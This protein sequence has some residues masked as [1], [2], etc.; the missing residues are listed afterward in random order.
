[1]R[2]ESDNSV[3]DSGFAKLVLDRPVLDS[4]C[5]LAI[6]SKS[7]QLYLHPGG[8]AGKDRHIF[9]VQR[10]DGTTLRLGPHVVNQLREGD[11]VRIELSDGEI[12]G[13][14][15]WTTLQR[16][17]NAPSLIRTTRL[18]PARVHVQ[19]TPRPGSDRLPNTPSSSEYS[20]GRKRQSAGLI[21]AACGIILMLASLGYLLLDRLIPLLPVEVR[22]HASAEMRLAEALRC[23]DRSSSCAIESTCFKGLGTVLAPVPALHAQANER[24]RIAMH[25]CDQVS[26]AIS[27]LKACSSRLRCDMASCKAS[28]EAVVPELDRA[29]QAADVAAIEAEVEARCGEP[30]EFARLNDCA[31]SQPCNFEACVIAYERVLQ[32][33][34]RAR[35]VEAI[36]QLRAQSQKHCAASEPRAT[37]SAHSRVRPGLYTVQRRYLDPPPIERSK[38]LCE[39]Q[40]FRMRI[41]SDGHVSW[42]DKEHE[43]RITKWIGRIDVENG[44]LSV[45]PEGI[46]TVEFGSPRRYAG[47]AGG[48]FQL[49]EEMQMEFEPCGKGLIKP[50]RLVGD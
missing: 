2:V 11:R 13:E 10:L 36:R 37:P 29:A 20:V 21:I 32:Q 9:E 24:L 22:P 26:R 14:L 23:A 47:T 48:T 3:T 12:A 17:T 42:E 38:A 7:L 41:R 34:S 39:P 35:R 4:I 46:A 31:S 25:G 15:E 1:M 30:R 33:E 44:H 45:G 5:G 27:E 49:G 16:G 18:D 19:G 6:W 40:E 50:L 8:K 43:V 28:Y